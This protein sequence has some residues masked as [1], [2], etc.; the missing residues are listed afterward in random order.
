MTTYIITG[1]DRTG[2][3]FKITTTN[4]IHA[5]GIN[6]YRGSKWEVLKS[7]ERKLLER[8]WN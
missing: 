1:T 7:D 5:E 6:L 3:R 2:K 4:V 8:V